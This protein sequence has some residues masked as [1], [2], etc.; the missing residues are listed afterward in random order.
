M[1]IRIFSILIGLFTGL[2][3]YSLIGYF[4]TRKIPVGQKYKIKLIFF[5]L[6]FII[7][8]LFYIKFK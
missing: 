5:S 2:S 3:V 7:T 1:K 6:V 8:V 4:Y